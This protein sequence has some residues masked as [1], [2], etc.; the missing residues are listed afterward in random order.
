MYLWHSTLA[1]L[2]MCVV[3]VRCSS[4]WLIMSCRQ[5]NSHLTESKHGAYKYVHL[6][7]QVCSKECSFWVGWISFGA[8]LAKGANYW[9]SDIWP[10]NVVFNRNPIKPSWVW[11]YSWPK[12][13][14]EAMELAQNRGLIWT[15]HAWKS[16]YNL[17]VCLYGYTVFCGESSYCCINTD[18]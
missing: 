7:L 18:N 6:L 12:L 11:I 16:L 1:L 10:K 15:K 14:P 5:I 2:C 8:T 4:I 13:P 9:K 3:W 17:L